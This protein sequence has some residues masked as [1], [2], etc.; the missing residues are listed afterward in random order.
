MEHVKT[1]EDFARPQNTAAP[2]SQRYHYM[3]NLRALAMLA[4]VV[5]H[6]LLAY[7]PLM[8][9]LWLSADSQNATWVDAI[10]WF[11]HL[12]R[13]PLFFLIAGFFAAYLLRKRGA[14]GLLRNRVLRIALPLVIFLPLVTV[15]ILAGIDW[16]SQNVARPSPMLELIK[17]LK[18]MP[19]Q[20]PPPFSFSHLWFL[21]QL[22]LFIPV[23]LLLG[24]LGFLARLLPADG[25]KSWQTLLLLPLLT[26][27]ALI[28]QT[29]PHPA[30]DGLTPHWWSFGFY[31][32]F[33]LFGGHLFKQQ[34]LLERLRPHVSWMLAGSASL[35][36]VYFYFMPK[37][38]SMEEIMAQAN[39]PAGLTL[40]HAA[41]AVAGAVV[42]WW[43]T[44]SSL[45]VGKRLLDRASSVVRFIADA[46]YW[47]YLIHLPLIFVIQYK[48]TDLDW[49]LWQKLTV[50]VALTL[51][52]GLASYALMVR[53]T[54]IGW[55]LNGRR[56][57]RATTPDLPAARLP[58]GQPSS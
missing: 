57:G 58:E 18:L 11:S 2:L 4:G 16:A 8:A 42:A 54:P 23:W 22:C 31:G 48:L 52:L 10:A 7:S 36:A 46:S 29:A 43:M 20:T 39:Q 27:P 30:P 38:V 13:M 15:A 6:A 51:L 3:D 1:G 5:F 45:I 26:V 50:S 21:Y 49:G 53:W 28:S 55:L 33:F 56:K 12:F 17:W 24:R 47:I 37:T 41:M 25:L 34:H 9:N 44:L 40:Q 19:E 35:Y 14:W 32:L